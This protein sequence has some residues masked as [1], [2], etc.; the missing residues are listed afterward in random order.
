MREKILVIGA[1]G[2]IGTE[3][4]AALRET[5]PPDSVIAADI[6]GE[7][8]SL[9]GR[10]P[11][12][13]L[14]IMDR[15]TLQV[16]VRKKQ[17]TQIYLLS[18]ILSATGEQYPQ[19]AWQLNMQGLI[20]TLEVAREEKLARVFWPSSIGVFG[21]SAPKTD[22]PQDAILDPA[23]VYGISKLA[24]E[25]WCRYYFDRY[26][27]DIRSLRYP[28]LIS[29]KTLPGGGTTDYAVEFF[30]HAFSQRNY[31]CYLE[32]DTRLPMMYMPDAIRAT[33]MLMEAYPKQIRIRSS[34]N[35]S[36]MS[37]TPEEHGAF[38]SRR[39]RPLEITYL[40]DYR[41]KIAESWPGS[42]DDSMARRDWN[43]KPV[44]GLEEMT[45]EMLLRLGERY[46]IPVKI[47]FPIVG[48]SWR[49]GRSLPDFLKKR[50]MRKSL[51]LIFYPIALIFCP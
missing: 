22:C 11:F 23:T 6:R 15:E 3:L 13:H 26:G 36:A 51:F 48:V 41:Q 27:L 8:D 29:Y 20:N 33:L 19:R 49:G 2:Q 1:C 40:P 10:G 39:L 45:K 42:I 47:L 12:I 32:P 34:Y 43:W 17:I 30:Q 21:A 37:F 24:G 18:A 44:Y 16:I 31:T 38:I 50:V 46:Q 35:I 7:T 25:Q 14:D 28:G 5:Y 4:V 9:Q